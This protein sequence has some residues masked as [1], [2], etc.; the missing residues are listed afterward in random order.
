MTTKRGG[1]REFDPTKGLQHHKAEHY[2]LRHSAAQCE[3]LL[4]K[5]DELV[6]ITRAQAPVREGDYDL[7]RKAASRPDD[8]EHRLEAAVLD[9][10]SGLSANGSAGKFASNCS[11]VPFCQLRIKAPG[12]RKVNASWGRIDLVGMHSRTQ[13][14]ILIELKQE[15]ASD[16][17]LRVICEVLAY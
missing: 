8:P 7:A 2:Q 1:I 16:P 10:W 17:L 6:A 14:P 4:A 5:L 12:Q 9:K 11:Q 15:K 13:Q 3:D